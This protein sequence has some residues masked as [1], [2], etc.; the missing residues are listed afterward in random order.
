M[1]PSNTPSPP[2][3]WFLLVDHS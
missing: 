1:I 2:C 3:P